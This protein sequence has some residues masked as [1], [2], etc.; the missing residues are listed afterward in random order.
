MMSKYNLTS[1]IFL[2]FKEHPDD[3]HC[4]IPLQVSYAWHS[5][6]RFGMWLNYGPTQEFSAE[7]IGASASIYS[8]QF[9]PNG[10]RKRETDSDSDS[11]EDRKRKP[12]PR[13]SSQAQQLCSRVKRAQELLT[14]FREMIS[15]SFWYNINRLVCPKIKGNVYYVFDELQQPFPL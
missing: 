7:A 5:A 11:D 3:D 6:F 15:I 1:T 12:K 13:I 8:C 9:V 4:I 14:M 10:S 2:N